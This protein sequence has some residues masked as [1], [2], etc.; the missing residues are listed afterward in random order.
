MGTNK[1]HVGARSNVVGKFQSCSVER[2]VEASVSKFDNGENF[3]QPIGLRENLEFS[4]VEENFGLQS[5]HDQ[6]D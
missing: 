5:V 6:C 3:F 1:T 4:R 2:P